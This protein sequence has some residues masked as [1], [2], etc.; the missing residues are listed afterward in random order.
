MQNLR[1]IWH[2]AKMKCELEL[3]LASGPHKF[4]VVVI[5]EPPPCTVNGNQYRVVMTEAFSQLTRATLAGKTIVRQ[6]DLY[7]YSEN[8]ASHV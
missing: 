1:T 2:T 6:L 7:N 8:L 5:L 4:V 3:F